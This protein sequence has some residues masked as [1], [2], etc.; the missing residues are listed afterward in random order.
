[1]KKLIIILIGICLLP[2]NCIGQN[3]K[4]IVSHK[5]L[6]TKIINT[7]KNQ[8]KY[9]K[10]I[11]DTIYSLTET[12]SNYIFISKPV[13][14]NFRRILYYNKNTLALINEYLCFIDMYI[15]TK[16]YDEN[17]NI[18]EK[19]NYDEGFENFTVNDFIETVKKELNI[20]LNEDIKGL[21]VSRH[22]IIDTLK[23][24]IYIY[25]KISHLQRIISINGNT[26]GIISDT[27]EDIRA[28]E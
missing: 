27:T 7:F 25:D 21:S 6:D 19:R 20:D 15:T 14:K 4:E 9:E 28:S 3:K 8:G 11:N 16:K 22:I 17:C 2:L 23:Y 1:M 24:H 18:I 12:E 13:G 26:R 5:K 10:I